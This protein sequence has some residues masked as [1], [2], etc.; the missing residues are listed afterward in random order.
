MSDLLDSKKVIVLAG[1]TSSGKSAA[2]L[3]IA[4]LFPDKVEIVI[5]D[6]VQ[7]YRDLNIASNK[8]TLEEQAIAPHHLVDIA[9]PI[10]NLSA[11]D[12]C[13]LAKE[14]IDDIIDR[15]KLPVIVG[16]STM[17]IKWLVHG[18]PDAPMASEY[19]V[20]TSV[21]LLQDAFS[22]KNW[23]LAVSILESYD[24]N[25]ASKLSANDWYRMHRYLEIAI[26]LKKAN[27]TSSATASANVE[28]GVQGVSLTN[29]RKPVLADFD[30]RSF[31]LMEEDRELLFHTIDSRCE[32]MLANG[33]LEEVGS[34]LLEGKLTP[35]AF[36]WKSIGYRQ[37]IDYLL[38]PQISENNME[39]FL[40]FLRYFIL[41]C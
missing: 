17:W 39:A 40:L 28:H 20:Q 30:V 19:A 33:L 29:D 38:N 31:F 32:A 37:T 16:G 12:F 9:N 22:T 6:S 36:V 35:D 41:F 4:K 5:A 23:P 1:A 15:G 11:G 18:V 7:V 21:E 2:S 27:E 13:I 25:L 24:S 14:K 26:D 3:E 10:D 34:L 8:P